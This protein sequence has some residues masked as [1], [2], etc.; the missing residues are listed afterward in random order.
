M[1]I[2]CYMCDSCI[3][4]HSKKN[5]NNSVFLS[6]TFS[7]F[8]PLGHSF[9]ICHHLPQSKQVKFEELDSGFL[10][11]YH[12][13]VRF[14]SLVLFFKQFPNF[15]VSRFKV[16]EPLYPCDSSSLISFFWTTDLSVKNIKDI[17]WSQAIGQRQSKTWKLNM[18]T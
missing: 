9:L 4:H 10:K 5:D 14:M 13:C 1:F 3:C 8:W 16:S 7:L 6:K 17:W 18:K 15:L 2:T 11:P 12:L